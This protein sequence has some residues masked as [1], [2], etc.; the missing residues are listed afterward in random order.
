MPQFGLVE[1]G[2]GE[3]GAPTGSA[4][5]RLTAACAG[6]ITLSVVKVAGAIERSGVASCAGELTATFNTGATGTAQCAG[7]IIVQFLQRHGQQESCISGS[8]AANPNNAVY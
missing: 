2:A 1:Y 5:L 7:E 8:G 4:P 3:F 6:K